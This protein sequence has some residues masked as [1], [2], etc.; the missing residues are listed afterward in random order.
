MRHDLDGPWI[1][2]REARSKTRLVNNEI[3]FS[4]HTGHIVPVVYAQNR[5]FLAVS[6][7]NNSLVGHASFWYSGPIQVG[8]S[9][10]HEII[11]QDQSIVGQRAVHLL[12]PNNIFDWNTRCPFK[13][14]AP[15]GILHHWEPRK[16]AEHLQAN[17]Q[18]IHLPQEYDDYEWAE[19]SLV[20]HVP[21]NYDE[22][23]FFEHH[24]KDYLI[25][26]PAAPYVYGTDYHSVYEQQ[27]FRL[28]VSALPLLTTPKQHDKPPCKYT[29][30]YQSEKQR[31]NDLHSVITNLL[32]HYPQAKSGFLWNTLRRDSQQAKRQFDRDECI[33]Q[34]DNTVIYWANHQG[35]PHTLKKRSFQNIVSKLRQKM[36]S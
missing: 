13:G 34:M 14:Q 27:D 20:E 23:E 6:R 7:H 11:T 26:S 4:I 17:A 25:R 12:L 36:S 18:V 3:L 2:L 30:P 24:A 19:S 31:T 15:N 35:T 28:P 8:H 1:T 29:P 9:V 16:K 33:T 21:V 22:D 32:Q 10:I 5:P